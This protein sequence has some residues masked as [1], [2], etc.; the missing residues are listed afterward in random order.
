MASFIAARLRLSLPAGVRAFRAGRAACGGESDNLQT[1][2]LK[3]DHSAKMTHLYHKLNFALIGL[4]PVAL[5]L[6]PSAMNYPLDLL[7]GVIIPLHSHI[8]GNDVVTDYAKKITKAKAFE[9][10]LRWSVLGT[11]VVMFFGLLKLNLEGH[12]I[13]ETIKRLWRPKDPQPR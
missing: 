6:S 11:S 10:T 4:G 5:V 2:V 12:G 9:S 13:T 8:G 7:L 1:M 3:S